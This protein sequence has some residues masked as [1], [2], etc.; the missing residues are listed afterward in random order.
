MQKLV[1]LPRDQKNGFI[2]CEAMRLPRTNSL[3][4]TFEESLEVFNNAREHM[5]IGKQS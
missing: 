2:E 1:P 3:K 5:A 4:T